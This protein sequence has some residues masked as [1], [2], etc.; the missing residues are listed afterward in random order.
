MVNDIEN[1]QESTQSVVLIQDLN[2]IFVGQTAYEKQENE[3]GKVLYSA[4]KFLGK[5][6]DDHNLT[7]FCRSAAFKIVED[8]QFNKPMY[9]VKHNEGK[10]T[11]YP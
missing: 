10:S 8:K 7:E 11:F 2:T 1:Q 3:L 4:K 5:N 9:E 6:F